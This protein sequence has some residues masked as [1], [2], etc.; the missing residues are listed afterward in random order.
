MK[1]KRGQFFLIMAVVIGALLLGAT[2]LFNKTE[3]S[4]PSQF[5]VLCE[6][7]YQEV[8]QLSKDCMLEN[9]E[10]LKDRIDDFTVYFGT[11]KNV[12]INQIYD[13]DGAQGYNS[14]TFTMTQEKDNEVYKCIK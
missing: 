14:F 2:A 3:V 7:Y 4:Q 5:N 12:E 11:Q 10:N 6:N 9:C 1:S 8:Q 13:N